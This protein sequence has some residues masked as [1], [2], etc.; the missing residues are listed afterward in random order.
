MIRLTASFGRKTPDTEQFSSRS[1]H[2]SA[3][4]DVMDSVAEDPSALKRAL[5]NIWRQLKQAVDE[6]IGDGPVQIHTGPT[7]RIATHGNGNNGSNGNG[8]S[9]DVPASRKQVG[10]LL[11]LARRHRNFSADQTRQWLR[12]DHNIELDDI[13]KSQATTLID[14]L[15][16]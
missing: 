11:S 7:N 6:E 4:F 14:T 16:G 2:A 9:H 3:E 10:F 13:T 5:S 1:V 15:K 8:R 12:K